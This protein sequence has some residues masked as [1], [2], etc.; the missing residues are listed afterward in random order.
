MNLDYATVFSLAPYMND[1]LVTIV[2][3]CLLIGAMAK[4]SQVG[5]RKALKNWVYNLQFFWTLIF[6][7]IASNALEFAGPFLYYLNDPK[8]SQGQ[9]ANQQGINELISRLCTN[10]FDGKF[11]EWFIGFTEGD[12]SFV[13]TG[14][15]SVFS[16]HLHIVDLPLLY[17]IQN[18]LNMGNVYFKDDS[19]TF[20]VKSNKDISTII[21]IFNGNLFFKKRKEQFSK[22]VYNYNRK[23]NINIEIKNNEFIPSL[24]N[25]WLSGFTDAEGS[26]FVSVSNHRIVQ[27]FS[28]T[29][30]DAEL[31]FLYLKGL[32][33]GN[34]EIYKTYSR[35][36]VNFFALDIIIDYLSKYKLHSVKAKSLEKWLEI[37]EYRKNKP[38]SEKIDYNVLKKKASLINQ[39]RKVPKI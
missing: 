39:L 23:N 12:G 26:F 34:Y 7:G 9:G 16:I 17:Y 38:S 11:L 5:H 19:A 30:K 33:K 6:A 27:R 21:Q 14:G 1:S 2:G 36:V 35:V 28:L 10:R 15:K 13:V 3:I 22:W 25:G 24:N 32:L 37:Y 8:K 20:I 4:S 18:Q 29:Q 31:E